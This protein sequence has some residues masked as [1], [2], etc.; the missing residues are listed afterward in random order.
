MTDD[1]LPWLKRTFTV[2]VTD[3]DHPML[4]LLMTKLLGTVLVPQTRVGFLDHLATVRRVLR[5]RHWDA[6]FIL[7][8]LYFCLFDF[9]LQFPIQVVKLLP[10]DADNSFPVF[11]H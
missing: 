1:R 5:I 9:V 7:S 6:A 11:P 4:L 2:L 10:P 8:A 3:D